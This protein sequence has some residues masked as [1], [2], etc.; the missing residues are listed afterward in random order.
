[1]QSTTNLV[2][3]NWTT[4]LPVPVVVNGRNTVTNPISDTQQFF[5]LN[6]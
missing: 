4:N 5:R 6:Q 3:P 1:V 2:S